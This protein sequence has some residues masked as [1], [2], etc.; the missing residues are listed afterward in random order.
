MEPRG[1]GQ[2]ILKRGQNPHT[3]FITA[4][5]FSTGSYLTL[6]VSFPSLP[7]THSNLINYSYHAVVCGETGSRI[8]MDTK[9]LR[10]QKPL[11]EMLLYLHVEPTHILL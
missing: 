11:C 5:V 4:K 3:Q 10:I 7:T 9:N 2:G 1:K 6:L 8:P